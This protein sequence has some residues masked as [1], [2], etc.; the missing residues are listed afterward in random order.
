VPTDWA[1]RAVQCDEDLAIMHFGYARHEDRIAKHARYSTTRGH[2][3][4]HIA[5]ILT[6]PQLV[7]WYD[8][9]GPW[10]AT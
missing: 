4:R 1:T 7:R 8:I 6:T 5:S 2:N 3:P 10:N 9:N